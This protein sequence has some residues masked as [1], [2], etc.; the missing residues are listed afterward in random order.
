MPGTVSGLERERRL[1]ADISRPVEAVFA[2][3]E[4]L[5]E[6][7]LS[8]AD[9]VAAIGRPLRR[10][11]LL[12]LR[13]SVADVL[14]RHAGLVAGAG[15]VMAPHSLADA[16]LWID[17][18][19]PGAASALEQLK[20]DLDP[21]SAE[22][23]DYTTTEWYREPERTGERH[24][25]GPYVDYICTHE[26]T[27]TLSAPLVHRGRYIGVAGADI[28][29]SRIERMVVSDLGRLP[30]VAA[31]VSGNGRVISSN[32]T[33]LMPGMI[34]GRQAAGAGLRPVA[35]PEDGSRRSPLPWVLLE[36]ETRSD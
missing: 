33:R 25:A 6:H 23:Y 15:V 35:G 7:M 34:A 22:F 27:F 9:S 1:L 28:L 17:W 26:Y 31:L 11:D 18:W 2:S 36:G 4:T 19:W 14:E 32:S 30:C 29:A 10:R 8:I 16:P 13:P 3:V 24:I 5:R 12:G 21:T 20:V